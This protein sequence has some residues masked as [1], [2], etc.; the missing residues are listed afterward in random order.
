MRCHISYCD[1]CQLGIFNQFVPVSGQGEGHDIM[2]IG[3]APGA[4]EARR[5]IPFV[6]K[7]GTLLKK[8][9]RYYSL[10]EKV[11][12]TNIVKCRPPSNRTPTNIERET[13]IK[14]LYNEIKIVKPKLILLFGL[15]A[16]N[17]FYPNIDYVGDR[18]YKYGTIKSVVVGCSYHPSYILRNPK[19][20]LEFAKFIYKAN[21]IYQ[22]LNPYFIKPIKI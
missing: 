11:Y 5:G 1:K 8:H 12:F 2:I 6:G 21:K 7:A 15:T 9:L 20:E 3:E 14:W 19:E 13:C 18:K 17:T 4:T 16:I 10:L 22:R